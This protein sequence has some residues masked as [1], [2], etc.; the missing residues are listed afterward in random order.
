M[1]GVSHSG[2]ITIWIIWTQAGRC[3]MLC[4]ICIVHIELSK[5]VLDHADYT[6]PTPQ[7]SWVTQI[8]NIYSLNDL[9]HEL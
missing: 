4:G 6:A 8:R 5:C 2:E 9:D 1:A 7:K 3:E